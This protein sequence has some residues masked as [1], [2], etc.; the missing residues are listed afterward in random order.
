M[1]PTGGIVLTV[2]KGRELV[3]DAD[4]TERPYKNRDA[5]RMSQIDVETAYRRSGAGTALYEEALA[6]A[7][8]KGA[9]FLSSADR[10]AFAESFWRKQAKRGRVRCRKLNARGAYGSNYNAWPLIE[11]RNTI[12]EICG[13]AHPNFPAMQ[14][15]CVEQ[16]TQNLRKL[17]KPRPRHIVG[18]ELEHYWPCFIYAVKP[19]HCKDGSFKGLRGYL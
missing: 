17:P 7:C 16:L 15:K 3:G 4:L 18:G 1:R 5:I 2:Y 19:D 13:R 14:R 9:L 8:E 11:R 12:D 10:S 6:V